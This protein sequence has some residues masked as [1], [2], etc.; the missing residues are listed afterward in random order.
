MSD[1]AIHDKLDRILSI[2]NKEE[3]TVEAAVNMDVGEVI[4]ALLQQNPK[5]N[6]EQL[7]DRIP[8]GCYRDPDH[9]YFDADTL[10]KIRSSV[11]GYIRHR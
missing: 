3:L 4:S 9:D 7:L 5:L 11:S 8:I 2:L 1:D 10:F 6:R